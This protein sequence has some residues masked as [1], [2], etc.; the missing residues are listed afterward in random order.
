M[1][2]VIIQGDN[3]TLDEIAYNIDDFP[4]KPIYDTILYGRKDDKITWY[5]V[6]CAFDIETTNMRLPELKD[7]YGFM[8]QWQFC[9]D[10][11]VVFGRTW[12]EFIKFF[13][14]LHDTLKLSHNLML[15]VYVHNLAFECQYMNQF[16][17]ELDKDID[18]FYPKKRQALIIRMKNYG[19]EFRCSYKLSNMSLEKFVKNSDSKY[20]KQTSV[21]YDYHKVRTSSTLLTMDEK[22]YCYCDVRGLCD[23]IRKE[24]EDYNIANIPLTSTGF[25]RRDTLNAYKYYDNMLNGR[26]LPTEW[27][28][29]FKKLPYQKS[30]KDGEK[31]SYHHDLCACKVTE[32][33]YL[34]EKE[35]SRGGDTHANAIYSDKVIDNVYSYDRVSSYPAV[36]LTKKYPCGKWVRHN[37]TK[38]QLQE[39]LHGGKA[40]IGRYYLS[41]VKLKPGN[42][43]PYISR[44]KCVEC[45]G[46]K[47][48]N[49]RIYRAKR[50]VISMTEIDYWIVEDMYEFDLDGYEDIYIS[51]KDYLPIPLR[52]VNYY[53]F[54]KKCEL[55]TGDPYY[56]MKSKNKLNGI[57]GMTFTDMVHESWDYILDEC[58]WVKGDAAIAKAIAKYYAN[59]NSC[60][61]YDTG[62]YTTAWARWELHLARKACGKYYIYSDTDSVKWFCEDEKERNR[63]LGWFEKRNKELYEEAV[64]M[65]AYADVNGKRYVLG[66]WEDEGGGTAEYKR[67]KTYGA[68]KYAVEY[69]DGRFEIT[70]AGL[71]KEKGSRFFKSVDNFNMGVEVSEDD[72]G[73]TT[74]VWRDEKMHYITIGGERIKTASSVALFETTYTL[75]V[76]NDY[77]LLIKNNELSLK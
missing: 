22:A 16:L 45:D 66:V 60:L 42:Y 54:I 43:S 50:I 14:R 6:P 5:N 68:K 15:C 65:G 31:S 74:A 56:Y 25:V 3:C 61:R 20:I 39:Y 30:I 49:G 64:R 9:L 67:F 47:C 75:D 11:R 21:K 72:S 77:R 59:Y 27:A 53:Y 63:I 28:K 8:Y 38:S 58:R 37:P 4:F 13:R 23:A 41:N 70:V 12:D 52:A 33:I 29:I 10:D 55:K 71:N 35:C 76:A 57:F 46:V 17:L 34:L 19:I 7:S 51:E 32:E 26:Y 40:V 36:Q 62:I 18:I 69:Q 73:R 24:L 1:E 2:H 48:D 44:H